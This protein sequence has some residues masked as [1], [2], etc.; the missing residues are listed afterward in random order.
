MRFDIL[1]IFPETFS[2]VLS[3]SILKRAIEAGEIEFVLHDIRQYA[4]D[5][6]RIVDDSPYGGGAGMLMKPD[7]IVKAFRGVDKVGKKQLRIFLTPQG[8]PLTQKVVRELASCDQITMLCGHY[9]GVDQR[10]RDMVID[11]EISVG[12]YVL[13][14][15]ELPAMVVCD[16][17]ARLLKG[18]LGNSDSH[19]DDSFEKGRLEYPQY[20]RPEDFEGLKVPK[21]LLTGHHKR[22]KEW[23]DDQS[24]K[25]TKT[26]R[27]D[28]L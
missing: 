17:V 12:D 27:S 24:L 15:G 20:T 2:S 10:V 21:I 5:A 7:P 1:T 28:L 6:H 11:R 8:E 23:R 18:V 16:A 4:D 19:K 14:G 25:K 3:V 22:I 9:E 13:T 26:V